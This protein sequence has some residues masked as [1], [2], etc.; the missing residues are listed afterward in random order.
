M[1][2]W[3]ALRSAPAGRSSGRKAHASTR[4]KARSRS[5][6]RGRGPRSRPGRRPRRSRCG[7]LRPSARLNPVRWRRLRPAC[8]RCR[9]RPRHRPR[10]LLQTPAAAVPAPAP[11][12]WEAPDFLQTI[13]AFFTTGNL[14]AKVG[15]VILFF[16]VAFLLQLRGRAGAVADRVPADGHGGRGRR[17]AGRR[18]VAAPDASGLRQGGAGRRGR[19]PLPDRLRRLSTL[20][21]RGRAAGA[22]VA[23]RGGGAERRAGGAA[24][25][26]GPGRARNHRRLPGAHPGLHRERQPRVAV[27]LLLDPQR[28]RGRPGVVPRVAGTE[29]AGIRLHVRRRPFLG[30]RVLRAGALRDHRT[31]PDRVLPVLCRGGRAV[32]AAAAAQP[33]RVTS[34][35]R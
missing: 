17:H 13:V 15:V 6:R 25:V 10:H 5:W 27:L 9:G 14:V 18:V 19:H 29:L 8:H 21:A 30:Q 1:A 7:P 32:R 3:P 22:G 23:A 34:T 2:R 20:R 26:A 24:V 35:A 33:A 4:W 16:G 28:R 31:V 12:V 11:A